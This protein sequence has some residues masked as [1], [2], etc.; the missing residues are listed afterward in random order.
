[1]YFLEPI[2][3]PEKFPEENWP[4]NFLGQDPDPDVSKVGSGSG[5]DQ[6]SSGS[7]TLV[8]SNESFL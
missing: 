6:K 5:S 8:V 4:T 2:F 3:S 1:M 7:A